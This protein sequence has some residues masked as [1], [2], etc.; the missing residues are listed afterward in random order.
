MKSNF[1]F[2]QVIALLVVL[3]AGCGAET[4]TDI[5]VIATTNVVATDIR[6]EEES[7]V[8]KQI[9]FSYAILGRNGFESNIASICPDGTDKRRLT[10]DA[11]GNFSAAWSP[12]GSEI[13][14]LSTRSGTRQLHVMDQDGGNNRQ[15]TFGPETVDWDWFWLP[16]G[17]KIAVLTT[18]VDVGGELASSGY[19]HKRNYSPD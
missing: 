1:R 3:V 5:R 11:Y 8:C 14:F 18:G 19:S 17:N 6:S 7:I 2:V 16:D 12:D 10:H 13:A 15:I 9:I 4:T